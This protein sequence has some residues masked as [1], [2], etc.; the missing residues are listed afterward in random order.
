[1]GSGWLSGA[2]SL[3]DTG[4]DWS[5]VAISK[6]N[7]TLIKRIDRAVADRYH[8]FSKVRLKAIYTSSS[9]YK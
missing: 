2:S 1:M 7:L 8:M 6:I 9:T 3:T 5:G 4:V